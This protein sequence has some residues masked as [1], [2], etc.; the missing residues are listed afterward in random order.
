MWDMDG[1]LGFSQQS[2]LRV[3][4]VSPGPEKLGG[5]LS[6]GASSLLHLLQ[7]PNVTH[8]RGHREGG[9]GG[10][11]APLTRSQ[12]RCSWRWCVC[13]L[14]GESGSD[15]AAAPV[16]ANRTASIC[17]PA[18]STNLETCPS[19]KTPWINYW[20]DTTFASGQTLEVCQQAFHVLS[21]FC[22]ADLTL[23][24]VLQGPP[25]A[26]GMSIDVA[27]IDMV[28]EV[29]MVSCGAAQVCPCLS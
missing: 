15:P 29:N 18:A 2:N 8:P 24:C 27:S 6:A 23:F 19:L 20:K 7:T 12:R 10:S 4:G 25:V 1:V 16:L 13:V 22:G 11:R 21:W 26:V 5:A 14:R 9:C 3:S 17:S 28:S